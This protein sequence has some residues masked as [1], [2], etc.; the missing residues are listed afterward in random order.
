M[1]N[2]NISA[3]IWEKEAATYAE[4]SC[5]EP[6]QQTAPITRLFFPSAK[7]G[8]F[9]EGKGRSTNYLQGILTD[10]VVVGNNFQ[11]D[12]WQFSIWNEDENTMYRL[13]IPQ[14]SFPALTLI[15]SFAYLLEQDTTLK[16]RQMVF[17]ASNKKAEGRDYA[18]VRLTLDGE[19]LVPFKFAP[20]E[21]A[22][23][24]RPANTSTRVS[25]LKSIVQQIQAAL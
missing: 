11:S 12:S 14:P 8:C 5:P 23:L 1:K 3:N 19:N 22:R 18:N 10:I 16:D 7:E 4:S 24:F 17:C 21:M 15:S 20:E 2:I 25:T 9:V 6:Q 13:E